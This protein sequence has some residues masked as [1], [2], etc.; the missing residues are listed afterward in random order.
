MQRKELA[1]QSIRERKVDSSGKE[2]Q[3]M[4]NVK[5]IALAG[6][7]QM[8]SRQ[9]NERKDS[10]IMGYT[11]QQQL[12]ESQLKRAMERAVVSGDYLDMDWLEA[13]QDKF[14]KKIVELLQS[15][16]SQDNEKKK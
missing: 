11:T 3:G 13:K 10:K 8:Q 16:T 7:I 9:T 15:P 6:V 1:K 5:R 12:L 14:S 4:T 2:M